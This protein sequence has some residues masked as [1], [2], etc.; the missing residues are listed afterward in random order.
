M[1]IN[2]RVVIRG[3]SGLAMLAIA[4]TLAISAAAQPAPVPV[5]VVQGSDGTMYVVQGGKSWTLVPGQISDSDVAALNPGGEIDEVL[6][7]DL[8]IQPP[9]ASPAATPTPASA[10]GPAPIT[11]T[12]DL[13]GKAGSDTAG[14]LAIAVGATITSVVDSTGK[15]HDFYAIALSAGTTYQILF[16][17]VKTSSSGALN[18]FVLNPDTS[19]SLECQFDTRTGTQ[20]INLGTPGSI[21]TFSPTVNG[22]YYIRMDAGGPSQKYTFTVK[23][24]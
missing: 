22:S 5:R 16:T 6:P 23:S 14:A 2:S 11:G 7:N 21:C 4:A 9:A 24:M 17:G 10:A 13:T 19:N 18:L 15:P 1:T 20:M 12:A 3:I 8:F